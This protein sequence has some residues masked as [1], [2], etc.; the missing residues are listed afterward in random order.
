MASKTSPQRR[1]GNLLDDLP[2]RST[3]ERF[4]S[5]LE[6]PGWRLERIV[7]TG[8]ATPPGQWLEQERAE[9]VLVLT[10]SAVLRFDGEAESRPMKPGD[11]LLIPGTTR[12]RV[13][14]TDPT[15]PTVWL[16]LHYD[17]E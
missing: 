16:A 17:A 15:Q 9:W 11:W 2:S 12:H 3:A 4:D 1:F 5:L 14:S 6:Q 8:Q 10:G 7:S 13:E